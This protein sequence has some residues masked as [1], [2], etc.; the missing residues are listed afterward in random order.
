MEDENFQR[1]MDAASAVRQRSGAPDLIYKTHNNDTTPAAS[2]GEPAAD[3]NVMFY[4]VAE[5]MALQ[6]IERRKEMHE[7]VAKELAGLRDEIAGLR[8][9]LTITRTVL[10]NRSVMLGVVRKEAKSV[11]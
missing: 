6:N 1:V 7:Y 2:V 9:D 8:A 10:S 11:A 3:S 4:A 5:A